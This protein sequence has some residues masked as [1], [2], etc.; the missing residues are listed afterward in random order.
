MPESLIEWG[1][2]PSCLEILISEDETT[3]VTTA[4]VPETGC[5]ID[6]VDIIKSV[7]AINCMT[8][9]EDSVRASMTTTT[10]PAL[11]LDGQQ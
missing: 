8:L 4:V 10:T 9:A 5:G 11:L 6:S 2:T 1:Q 3:C 7:E